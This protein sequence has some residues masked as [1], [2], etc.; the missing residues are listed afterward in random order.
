M[1]EVR[2]GV[3]CDA[4]R[5]VCEDTAIAAL[6]TR[7]SWTVPPKTGD[8][9][10]AVG[11]DA[12]DICACIKHSVP[13]ET[14]QALADGRKKNILVHCASEWL[15]RSLS[16][17]D[18]YY[19]HNLE[20]LGYSLA[21][22]QTIQEV[23][24]FFEFNLPGIPPIFQA[25]IGT[26]LRAEIR[27]LN[28]RIEARLP[29]S[30]RPIEQ[31]DALA[32]ALAALFRQML[33]TKLG[34]LPRK[35]ADSAVRM[36]PKRSGTE[37]LPSSATDVLVTF[38]PYASKTGHTLT[39]FD[40]LAGS[41]FNDK[42]QQSTKHRVSKTDLLAVGDVLDAA[43]FIPPVKYLERP[44]QAAVKEFNQKVGKRDAA[45]TTWRKLANHPFHH[46]WMRRKLAHAAEKFR[47][48]RSSEGRLATTF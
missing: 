47:K 25:W 16:C 4:L 35:V 32:G 30:P 12:T 10:L 46:R 44:G 34:T 41:Q 1:R 31:W 24:R 14:F 6:R 9:P 29:V 19:L 5:N 39:R 15:T 13:R 27:F 37:A 28:E 20:T 33:G 11:E 48:Q 26:A 22:R 18:E 8:G 43:G 42:L 36:R 2:A 45:L 21:E 17:I 7:P 3:L 40:E 23:R 38:I